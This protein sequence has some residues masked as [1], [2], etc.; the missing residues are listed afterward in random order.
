MNLKHKIEQYKHKD[1]E[2]VQLYKSIEAE[3]LEGEIKVNGESFKEFKARLEE[4][5]AVSGGIGII[6]DAHKFISGYVNVVTE[7]FGVV[8]NLLKLLSAQNS[9]LVAELENY[10]PKIDYVEQ[11]E[12]SHG[13]SLEEVINE[14]ENDTEY[15]TDLKKLINN[16]FPRIKWELD[17]LHAELTKLKK[18]HEDAEVPSEPQADEELAEE[19]PAEQPPQAE[20]EAEEEPEGEAEPEVF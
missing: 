12:Q 11:F 18:T 5:D 13:K 6:T 7:N 1:K 20:P 4:F 14:M 17:T 8:K 9:E 16:Y 10:E 15:L 3:T 19:A 2:N